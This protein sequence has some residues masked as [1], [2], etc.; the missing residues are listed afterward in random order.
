MPPVD[1]RWMINQASLA[2]VFFVFVCMS[3]REAHPFSL[4]I[5]KPAFDLKFDGSNLLAS[6][7]SWNVTAAFPNGERR[8]MQCKALG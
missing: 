5:S 4:K 7:P 1:W 2:F 3:I 8:K 6:R